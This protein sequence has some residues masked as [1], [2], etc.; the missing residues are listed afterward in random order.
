MKQFLFMLLFLCLATTARADRFWVGGTG[1]W[2][3]VTTTHWSTSSG[4]AGGA[5]V[6]TSS[7]NAFFDG[8]SGGGTVTVNFGGTVSVAGVVL[9]AFTGTWDNSVNNNNF[10]LVGGGFSGTGVGTRTIK[11]GTATYTISNGGTVIDFATT[12]NLT[13]NAGLETWTWSGTSGARTVNTGGKSFGSL[14]MNSNQGS[15]PNSA[16]QT[17]TGN[18]TFANLTIVGPIYLRMTAGETLTV[19]GNFTWTGAKDQTIA[20]QTTTLGSTATIV[21]T[22]GGTMSYTSLRD[23]AFTTGAVTAT[24]SMD[25]GNNSGVTING[26]AASGG[27]CILGGWL[28]YRDLPNH[29]NDNFPAWLEKAA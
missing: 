24:N 15:Q 17:F 5:S 23:I 6:P 13:L 25:G 3:A 14:T 9:G 10:N 7:D 12:T 16:G 11:L 26:L 18:G 8:S 21:A 27:A 1:T 29:L 2:D 28:L 22:G 20:L 4:G 19:T